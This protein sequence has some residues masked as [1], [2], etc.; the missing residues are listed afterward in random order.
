MRTFKLTVFVAMLG[1]FLVSDAETQAICSLGP[2][3]G[4]PYNPYLD[5]A[6]SPRALQELQAIYTALCPPP[7]GCGNYVL[8]SNPSAPTVLW[9]PV[10]PG[11]SKFA[12]N[13][14]FTEPACHS[15]RHGRQL[16]AT[17]PRLRTP[18]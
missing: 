12:Y 4:Q 11:Y 7:V 6:P 8:F 16:W 17:C 2:T 10:G 5:Q 1:L 18:Y 15:V 9:T 14:F 13:P 3:A